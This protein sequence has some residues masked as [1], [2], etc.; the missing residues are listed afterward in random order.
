MGRS[1]T[2]TFV[3]EYRDQRGWHT[4]A[5]T[6]AQGKTQVRKAPTDEEAEEWRKT[7]NKS[8]QREGSNFHVSEAAGIILHVSHVVVKQNVPGG[9]TVAS[10]TM[11]MF[12]VV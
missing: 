6:N 5:W 11:P 10:A 8:F 9:R 4:Q 2:P 12:E 3:V 7:M 1:Y